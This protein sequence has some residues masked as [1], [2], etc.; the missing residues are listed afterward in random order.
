MCGILGGFSN[1]EIDKNKLDHHLSLIRHR[2]PDSQG[3]YISSDRKVYFGHTRLAI[4]DLSDT[5]SQPMISSDKR[6]VITYN[7]EVYNF[8]EIKKKILES[9]P[10][11]IFKSSGDTEVILG[12]IETFGFRES[13]SMMQ[14]MF[15]IGAWDK[16]NRKLMLARDRTGE[17]PLYYGLNSNSIFFASELKAL[18][19][20]FKIRNR[21]KSIKFISCAR[22]CA[23]TILYF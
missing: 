5:G 11:Y 2:G 23:S 16:K 7:G 19:F 1:K 6:Y 15:A 4:L 13:L 17:K 8:D 10:R 18:S 20:F 22:K 21:F 14:G 12:A 9:N 3:C